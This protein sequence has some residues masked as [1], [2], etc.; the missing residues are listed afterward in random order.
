[1]ELADTSAWTN[2][3]KDAALTADF[4][5][6]VESGEVATCH[7]VKLELLWSA[8]DHASFTFVRTRLDEL[9]E[10][11]I[12]ADVWVRA[13]DVFERLAARGPLHHRQVP[14]PDLLIAAAAESAGIGLCHY[15]VHFELIAE[16]TGQPMRAIAPLG[17]LGW[18]CGR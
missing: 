13:I 2:F 18:W 6:L 1:V 14:T 4:E 15:D 17:S 10:C 3:K 16:V 8:R 11:P 12:E 9:V 7:M 5:R